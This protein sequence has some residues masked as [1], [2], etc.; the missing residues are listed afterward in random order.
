M[1][2]E[3][4]SDKDFIKCLISEDDIELSIRYNKRSTLQR[5]YAMIDKLKEVLRK[6]WYKKNF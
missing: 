1:E 2:T 5:R 4:I 6:I 3:K